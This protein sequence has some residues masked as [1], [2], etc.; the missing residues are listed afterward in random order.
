MGLIALE[1]NDSGILAAAG[2][3]PEL[4]ELDGQFQESPGF[5]LPKKKNLIV[6]RAAASKAHYFPRL[7]LHHFWDQLNTAPLEKTGRHFPASHA[8]IVFRHLAFMWEQLKPHGDAIVMAVPSFFDRQQMGLIL[9]ISQELGMPINGFVPLSLAAA[10]HVSSGKMLLHLDIHLHRIE[11]VYLEQD[12]DLSVRDFATT[13]ERGVHRLYRKLADMIA[14]EFVRTT[15]FDPF[16]QA[17]SEQ[18]LYDRLPELLPHFKS[19][20]SLVFEIAGGSTPYSM[21]LKREAIIREAESTYRELLRLIKRMQ[22][23]RKKD[24]ASLTLQL[25]N[26][27]AHLPG[28]KKMLTTLQNSQIIELDQGAGALG[29]LKIWPQLKAQSNHEGVSFFTSRPWQ[30]PKTDDQRAT[31]NVTMPSTPTHLLYRAIAYP[32]SEKPLIVGSPHSD[33]QNKI[34]ISE[35]AADVFSK[36]CTLAMQDG[37]IVLKDLG[38]VEIFVDEQRVNGSITLKPGQFIRVG[39]RSERLQLIVCLDKSTLNTI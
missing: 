6:G 8:E 22:N 30:Q 9:G 2:D 11:V 35:A 25:S 3:P 10:S 12:G 19:N 28:C 38:E 31:S 5:A 17:A 33:Q 4:I 21:I 39:N 36:H 26:R 15:R 23:K 7:I 32:I 14:Q 29:A 1:L 34:A 18:E 13:F 37:E 20:S 24:K 27:L 16:H